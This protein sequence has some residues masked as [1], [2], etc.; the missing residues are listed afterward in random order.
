MKFWANGPGELLG[1]Q[2]AT[3]KPYYFT[4]STW[5]VNS[6]VGT[7]GAG[8][9]G[10]DREKPLATL[11]QA[12]TNASAGDTVIL[13]D[14]HS[15][16][17]TAVLA[18]NKQLFIAGGG[19]SGGIPTVSFTMNA[20]AADTFNVSA[21]NTEIRNIWFKESA[22]ANTGGTGGKIHTSASGCRIIG[23]YF[24]MGAND[25][26]AG[27]LADTAPTSL[28]VESCTFIST[29]TSRAVRPAQG[30]TVRTA[31]SDV[32]VYNCIFSDGAVGFSSRAFDTS[33]V[34]ITRLRI[35]NLSL[36]LGA[37][38]AMGGS[39]TGFISGITQ[40]GGGRVDW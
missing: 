19:S 8:S 16:T 5:F 14:G 23:C 18:I 3:G 17:L 9:A 10:L 38:A 1:D 31:A 7:D 12:I 20:A 40:T 36:L 13:M 11:G 21:G 15:E 28:R 32:E 33:T 2:L 35:F 39:S 34:T 22:Q 25:A 27:I 26:Y 29:A 37:S 30:L 6:A 4:A 24:S